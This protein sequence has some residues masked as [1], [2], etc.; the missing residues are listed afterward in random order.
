[1]AETASSLR[2]SM[3]AQT[4]LE[5]CLI[6][7][8]GWK[9]SAASFP[10]IKPSAPKAM[11]SINK[12]QE[13]SSFAPPANSFAPTLAK[14]NENED[15]EP[16]TENDTITDEPPFDI[17]ENE[18]G[19]GNRNQKEALPAQNRNNEGVNL[20]IEY[21]QKQWQKVLEAVKQKSITVNAFL[22]HA[23][24]GQFDKNILTLDFVKDY[25]VHMNNIVNK[26]N[27]KK[28]LELC[29]Q[30]VFGK[31]IKITAVLTEAPEQEENAAVYEETQSSLFD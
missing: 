20:S 23:Y 17:N 13:K 3:Q 9:E 11:P 15:F 18:N 29:L 10:K 19:A 8:C 6:K 22:Q 12:D 2:N 21:I 26:P 24:P 31:E 30:E 7:C 27:N 16:F 1:M 4:M 25:A 14:A 5:I 28:I